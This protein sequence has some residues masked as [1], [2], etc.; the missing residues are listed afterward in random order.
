MPHIIGRGRYGRETYPGR[1]GGFDLGTVLRLYGG[2][3]DASVTAE[4]FAANRAQT[5]VWLSFTQAE[6]LGAGSLLASSDYPIGNFNVKR[7]LFGGAGP[8]VGDADISYELL[9]S[10]DG[11]ATWTPP[12]GGAAV[13]VTFAPNE[14]DDKSVVVGRTI[15]ANA[16]IAV[17]AVYP[18]NYNPQSEDEAVFFAAEVAA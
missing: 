9:Q 4:T 11:G 14:S 10:I 3:T 5:D 17:R 12:A 18:T 6:I 7:V 8:I 2:S 15:P 1:S 16:L 13:I